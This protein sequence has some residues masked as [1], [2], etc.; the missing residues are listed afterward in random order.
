M[1]I[2]EA[3]LIPLEGIEVNM[4]EQKIKDFCLNTKCYILAYKTYEVIVGKIENNEIMFYESNLDP[5][6]LLE[7]RVFND[8]KELHIWKVDNSFYGRERI[9]G[10]GDEEKNVYEEDHLLEGKEMFEAESGWVLL[11]NKDIGYQ[12]YYP[13]DFKKLSGSNVYLKIKNYYDFDN[14][15]LIVFNDARLCGFYNSE[16]QRVGE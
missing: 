9:D 8:C 16:K 6:Q 10:V 1:S 5:E 7:L 14:D 4:I 3:S 11:K 15:G 12:V 2:I 13:F